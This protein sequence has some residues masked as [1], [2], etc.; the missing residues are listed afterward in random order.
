MGGLNIEFPREDTAG[1]R[2]MPVNCAQLRYLI[3]N[4]Y[5][6]ISR[7]CIT[8]AD[9]EARN[10]V[11]GIGRAIGAA[12]ALWFVVNTM[13]RVAQGLHI[14]TMELTTLAFVF[15]MVISSFV[16]WRKPMD[17]SYPIFV[18]CDTELDTIIENARVRHGL[19]GS[20]FGRTPLSFLDRK[21]WFMSQI[22]ESYMQLLRRV[23]R[24]QPRP[25]RQY[26]FSSLDFIETSIKWDVGFGVWIPIYSAIFM[27][28]WNNY[29]PTS[30]EQLLWRISSVICLVYGVIG[31]LIAFIDHN[32]DELGQW[33][34]RAFH[35]AF[36]E[37][38]QQKRAKVPGWLARLRNL[39]PDN[40]PQ[41]EMSLAIW[42]PT[43]LLCVMYLF[44][45]A[46]ILFED[47]FALR[48]Q[49]WSTYQTVD[50]NQYS[51]LF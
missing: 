22:W 18:K 11:D 12:Q 25:V 8:G 19:Q 5:L 13:G 44:S 16:W 48:L 42:I 30:T 24:I 20:Q 3:D 32:S 34:R 21:E 15:L 1:Q 51:P 28:S 46:F 38:E 29:F 49:P 7:V 36:K 23:F 39:S 47:S 27:A 43:T 50:W 10:K 45:R 41:W 14:T 9:I 40:D 6:D 26:S 17:V 33:F 35:V 2:S 31:C 4:D 37:K